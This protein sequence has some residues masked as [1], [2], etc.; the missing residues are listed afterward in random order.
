MVGLVGWI[1]FFGFLPGPTSAHMHVCLMFGESNFC[2]S[3]H[4]C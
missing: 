2:K 4:C 3:V 1:V